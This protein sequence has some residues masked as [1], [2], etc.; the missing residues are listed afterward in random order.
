M[1][2]FWGK[3]VWDK[4]VEKLAVEVLEMRPSRY[5]WHA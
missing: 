1:G 2:K 5:Y 4:E 3:A